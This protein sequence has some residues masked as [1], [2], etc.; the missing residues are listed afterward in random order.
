MVADEATQGIDPKGL[1][2]LVVGKIPDYPDSIFFSLQC[3]T[4]SRHGRLTTG[5]GKDCGES[6]W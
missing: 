2:R 6:P 1:R 4:S 3:R 5:N